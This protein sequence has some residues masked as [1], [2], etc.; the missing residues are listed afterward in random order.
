MATDPQQSER[1]LAEWKALTSRYPLAHPAAL[2]MPLLSALAANGTLCW[3]VSIRALSPFELVLLVAIE[4]ILYLLIAWLQH[5]PV[6]KSAHLKHQ[7]VSWGAR[8]GMSLFALIWLGGVYGMVLL[9]WL[10]QLGE[11]KALIADPIGF[12]GRSNIWIP[13]AIAV[14][15]ASVD[16]ALDWRHWRRHGGAF[17]ST[18]AMTGAARWLTLFLG[19]FPFLMPMFLILIAINK[20]MEFVQ[21]HTGKDNLWV[22]LLIPVMMF[23]VFGTMGWLLSAGVSGFAIGYVVAKLASE[24]LI[25]FT[26]WIG[27]IAQKEAAESGPRK[28]RKGVL[29]G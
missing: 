20:L 5:L 21:K 3:L 17:V 24:C 18:P 23:S 27:K 16:A 19:G 15:G 12:L 8:L 7:S 14:A 2:A 22:M 1:E 9:V 10:G 29:P 11:A 26:P 13:L 28:G 25:V 4:S 6:P